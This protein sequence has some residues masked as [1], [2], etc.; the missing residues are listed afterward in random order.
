M[1]SKETSQQ[2][3]IK[4]LYAQ[5]FG[6]VAFFYNGQPLNIMGKAALLLAYLVC[7]EQQVSRQDLLTLI[8]PTGKAH[9]LRQ[10][11]ASLRKVAGAAEWLLDDQKTLSVVATSDVGQFVAVSHSQPA[12]A[13]QLARSTFLQADLSACPDLELWAEEQRQ[14]LAELLQAARRTHLAEC[15]AQQDWPAA[16]NQL[17]QLLQD[18]PLDEDAAEQLISLHL[19]RGQPHQASTVYEAFKRQLASLGMQPQPRVSAL[20]GREH[21]YPELLAQARQLLPSELQPASASLWSA[22]MDLPELEVAQWLASRLPQV[23][24]PPEPLAKLWQGRMARYFSDNDDKPPQLPRHRYLWLIAQLWEEAG[25]RPE[26]FSY[27]H[28]AT[29]AAYRDGANAEALAAVEKALVLSE[30]EERLELLLRKSGLLEVLGKNDELQHLAQEQ[31]AYAQ[32]TQ[33]DLA[34][35]GAYISHST[36]YMRQNE[37]ATAAD[38][39]AQAQEILQRIDR[40]AVSVPAAL[41]GR[42]YLLTGAVALR[43]GQLAEAKRAFHDGL[44]FEVPQDVRLRLLANL[45]ALY[46]LAGDFAQ[47]LQTLE[48]CLSVARQAGD[49][50]V[51]AGVLANLATTA[52]RAGDSM[53][54]QAAF[55]ESVALAG[56][57]GMTP[58]VQAAYRNLA[59]LYL[60]QGRL[61]YAYNTAQ[62]LEDYADL[63][64]DQRLLMQLTLAE[65]EWLCGDL[66]AAKQRLDKLDDSIW[67]PNER[68]HF[69]IRGFRLV[70]K[71]LLANSSGAIMSVEIQL[72]LLKQIADA[73]HIDLV[74]DVGLDLLTFQPSAEQM[75]PILDYL[76]ASEQQSYDKQQRHNL[77]G[78]FYSWR[79]TGQ[80]TAS[81]RQQLAAI[82]QQHFLHSSIAMRLLVATELA[83]LA[84]NSQQQQ[85]LQQAVLRQSEA[86]PS[87]LK[88]LFLAKS[89][90]PIY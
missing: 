88:E 27:Y 10:T 7:Q 13:L 24:A 67:A 52:E 31:L 68:Q 60:R 57:L 73:G 56:R 86:L 19:Q 89:R 77:A 23:S 71:Q 69:L 55:Q 83:E 42:V 5:L 62:D 76:G 53:R 12:E 78:L 16:Q 14:H 75:R 50:N 72:G 80:L 20:L 79:S 6:Q 43:S 32:V 11:L 61:G 25:S 54:A 35:L 59:A 49:L 1:Q 48:D 17:E 15:L 66:P 33:S 70:L 38:Y 47:S 65:V 46:G 34:F 40:V 39:L 84:A 87:H 85:Q 22:I 37:L 18:N 45:G 63:G 36:A 74:W 58:T 90:Q 9:N 3:A 81:Q 26:A 41:R 21:N 8:W 51:L 82:C 28:R 44:A 2:L 30:P 64:A 4:G 29:K